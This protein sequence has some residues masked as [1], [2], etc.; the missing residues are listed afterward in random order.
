MKITRE[1]AGAINSHGV[2]GFPHEVC[3]LLVGRPKER[4]ITDVRRL[5]NIEQS[6]PQVRYEVDPME[7]MRLRKEIYK[8]DLDVLGYYHSHPNHPAQASPTDA[9]R[10]WETYVYVIVSIHD[11]EPGE[12]NAFVALKDGGPMKQI[13]LEVV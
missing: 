10:A 11:G 3:G 5:A 6:Q 7:D 8:T 12:M 1:A 13:D 2:E 9:G 4:L